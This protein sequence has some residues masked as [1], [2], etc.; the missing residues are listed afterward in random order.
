MPRTRLFGASLVGILN[1]EAQSDEEARRR[2]RIVFGT[3]LAFLFVLDI[4]C[5]GMAVI[6]DCHSEP[7][8]SNVAITTTRRTRRTR[9][10]PPLSSQDGTSSS[11]T[12][13][14]HVLSVDDN[15][16]DDL[17]SPTTTT[18]LVS[19]CVMTSLLGRRQGRH[20]FQQQQQLMM[21][22][23]PKL[24][25]STTTTRTTRTT[26]SSGDS[27]TSTTT[28]TSGLGDLF[29]L[30]VLRCTI[31]SLLLWIGVSWATQQRRRQ[32]H[33][34]QQPQP[35]DDNN[36]YD[37]NNNNNDSNIQ[38]L[39]PEQEGIV[40]STNNNHDSN[41]STTTTTTTTTTTPPS[42]LVNNN[43]NDSVDQDSFS[44]MQPLL[45]K[46]T[47][48]ISSSSTCA[49]TTTT[50][51]SAT[52]MM[53]LATT[54][55]TTQCI[56]CPP[57]DDDNDD[58]DSGNSR[59]TGFDDDDEMEDDDDISITTTTTTYWYYRWLCRTVW[60]RRQRRRRWTL[61]G[62]QNLILI[63]LFVTCTFYQVYAGLRIATLKL[64]NNSQNPPNNNNNHDNHDNDNNNE[65]SSLS[66]WGHDIMILLL[67]LTILW[68]N[69]QAYVFRT[70]LLELTR[71]DGLFVLPP[72]I[73]RHPVFWETGRGLAVH[74]CD[75]CDTRIGDTMMTNNT[76][77]NTTTTTNTTTNTTNNT[78]NTNTTN[79]GTTTITRTT[80]TV[81]QRRR[82]QGRRR[83]I[84]DNNNNNNY[85]DMIPGCYRCSLCDFDICI[86]CANRQDAAIVGENILRGDRGVRIQE[87]LS[88]T[89][90]I[91]RSIQVAQKEL[92]LLLI[93]FLLLA[94]NSMT[95]LLLPHYQGSI[96]D[97]VV[98]QQQQQQNQ[99]HT[100]GEIIYDKDGFAKYIQL[101]IWIMIVQGAIATLYS[102]IFTLVSRRLKFT[103]L[104]QLF[105]KMLAQDVAYYD[106]TE[107][108]RL[109][110][111][112]TVD[113]NMMMDPIQ[114]SLSL[115]VKNIL[116]LFGGMIM[117]FI[118]SY[119]LSMLAF[120]TVGP[121]SYLWD[122][123]A[124]W[125]RGLARE[126]ISNWSEGNGIAT[127][128]IPNIR[129]VKA[130]GCEET[131][132]KHYYDT[133][134]RA[135]DCGIKDAWGNGFTMALT[136]YLDLG[137]GVLILFFGGHLIFRGEMSVGELIVF[138]LYWNM[139]NN[140]YQSLQGL[141]TNFTRSAAGAENVFAMFDTE[142]DINPNQ[143]QDIDWI[144]QGQ[145]QFQ[146]VSFYYQMRPNH[147]VL[148]KLNLQIP[149]GTSLA[150][151]GR[152]GGGKSTIINLLL[153]FYDVKDGMILLDGYDYESLNVVQLRRQFGVVTQETEL[154]PLS[155]KENIAYGLE[156]N[157][158]TMNDIIHAA[159]QACAHDFIMKMKDGYETRIGERGLRISG[160]QRQRLAIAR[161]FLRQPKIILLDEATS[162]LDEHSQD[163]V[164]TALMNL[165]TN[166]HATIILVAHR[167]STI[168][169]ADCICVLDHGTIVEQGNHDELIQQKPNGI[170]ASMVQRQM[171][172][173]NRHHD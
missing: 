41:V 43:N 73:H 106:G 135:L 36:N 65:S 24:F 31:S 118:K 136:G 81:G 117:C 160:G 165:M 13:R 93:S 140:A 47:T 171:K 46:T 16:D 169:H 96:I 127:Q 26:T 61:E 90:Y 147:M 78:T 98:P 138:Q 168:V 145:L 60:C 151:V 35:E 11:S 83:R 111:R 134:K 154:F 51:T 109:I 12:K 85:N 97:K 9:T 28:R 107:S 5:A 52:A 34:Q 152:S 141:I 143:G 173:K 139:M 101:Y 42:P 75:L 142:P 114:S 14:R 44:L 76:N 53:P 121:I 79:N 137:T 108:G 133:N 37:F 50:T 103:L 153:R 124:Q 40:L 162:A 105:H 4:T 84:H 110:S 113:L 82:R 3:V 120:V 100:T 128:A 69:A 22:I 18:T 148:T 112:L 104:I 91:T 59:S 94:A 64:N 164:Q 150:L 77:T 27:S 45:T 166:C 116:I 33:E 7:T 15:N 155:V 123:Y 170:Y 129:T 146:N 32:R 88:T 29:W 67:C 23:V 6:L 119:R 48:N 159:K 1:S 80:T 132:E 157:Q 62:I 71:Q 161:V 39:D 74:H 10:A 95:N 19:H 86:K 89:T 56:P 144:V 122:Q 72:E 130:F 149:A 131:I 125:S 87:S 17:G 126:M 158:Y 21:M 2:V 54:T 92:P 49:T 156:P 66:I 99:N 55:T 102:A 20:G 57:D 68:I 58:D 8:T 167:L 115:L 172:K 163:A 63:S 70:L 38:D 30:A 25:G